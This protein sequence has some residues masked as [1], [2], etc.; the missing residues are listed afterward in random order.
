MRIFVFD[1]VDRSN[2]PSDQYHKNVPARWAL[3]PSFFQGLFT[4]SFTIGLRDASHGRVRESEWCHALNRLKDS[5][6]SCPYCGAVAYWDDDAKVVAGARPGVC[7]KCGQVISPPARLK[8]DGGATI[9]LGVDTQLLSRHLN[10]RRLDIA[11]SVIARVVKHPTLPRVMGLENLT[12]NE[13]IVMGSDGQH[14]VP[15]GKRVL[16]A[17]GTEIMFGGGRGSILGD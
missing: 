12:G 5:V 2:R 17:S 4:R 13:W 16:I 7:W 6:M 15:L 14:S 10:P 1:P 11:D 3:Y 8:I 9:V